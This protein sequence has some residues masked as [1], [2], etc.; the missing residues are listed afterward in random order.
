ML[1]KN[2][3]SSPQILNCANELISHNIFRYDKN[4]T[5]DNNDN[6]KPTF[7]LGDSSIEESR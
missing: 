1:E 6:D 5:T 3:R 4:L 7:F 2:Y